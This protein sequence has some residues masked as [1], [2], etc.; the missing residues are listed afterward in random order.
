MRSKA[1]SIE[2]TGSSF[3]TLKLFQALAIAGLAGGLVTGRL[4]AILFCALVLAS[5]NVARLWCRSAGRACELKVGLS[6]SR[7]YPGEELAISVEARNRKLLPIWVRAEVPDS[8]GPLPLSGDRLLAPDAREPLLSEETGLLA[9]QQVTWQRRVTAARRGVYQLGPV[10]LEAG[11]PLGFFRQERR[12]DDRLELLVYPRLVAL[13]PLA[14]PVREFFGSRSAR[15]SVEDPARPVG[16]RD[17]HGDRPARH[18]NWKTSARV[19]KLLEKIHEPTAQASVLFL[20]DAASFPEDV[21]GSDEDA[22]TGPTRAEL[23]F[24]EALEVVASLA[25]E[26]ERLRVPVGLALNGVLVG[27]TEHVLAPGR[28]P[29][30]LGALLG[31]LARLGRGPGQTDGQFPTRG[32]LVGATTTCLYLCSMLSLSRALAI[33]ALQS[34]FRAPFIVLL[35]ELARK[36]ETPELARMEGEAAK[37]TI[38]HLAAA[39]IPTVRLSDLAAGGS[40]HA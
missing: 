32:L 35:S 25:V 36:Y 38:E 15:T 21:P 29:Y 4:E 31:M 26:M 13:A 27:K 19:D 12:G 10:R 8:R 28:G 33:E 40:V 5:V 22:A 11:D 20:L 18:I 1:L 3:V 9:F 17:Y 14:L 6:R 37:R 23:A 30:Q 16:T 2:S 39:G 7:L 24:E 34:R